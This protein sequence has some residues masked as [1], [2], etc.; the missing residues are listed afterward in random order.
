MAY[1]NICSLF[2]YFVIRLHI[3]LFDDVLYIIVLLIPSN[4]YKLLILLI[5]IYYMHLIL[6]L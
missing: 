2:I 1:I 5:S 4:A 6:Y 3:Y